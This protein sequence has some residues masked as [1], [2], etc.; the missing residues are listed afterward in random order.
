MDLLCYPPVPLYTSC[1]TVRILSLV[2][3]EGA[4]PAA[5]EQMLLFAV[6]CAESFQGFMELGVT[7]GTLMVFGQGELPSLLLCCVGNS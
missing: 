6:Q 2:R 4:F 5:W 7:D 3:W 1:L